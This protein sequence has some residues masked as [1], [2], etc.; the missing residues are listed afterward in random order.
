MKP[1]L[2][3]TVLALGFLAGPLSAQRP[4]LERR[5]MDGPRF[6]LTFVAG[7]RADSMLAERNLD[8]LMSQFG[9]HFEQIVVPE[10]G[11]PMFVIQE[12]VMIGA[13]EQRIAIPSLSLMMGVRFPS[14]FEFGVGPNVTP[15][16]PALAIGIGRSIDY[17]G[18]S[19]PLNLVL[20]HSQGAERFGVIIGYAIQGR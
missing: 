18:V 2:T 5:S 16:G 12:V 4:E 20:V 1:T 9:W 14:G 7:Q 11:G 6:G 10:G 17:R 8:P 3:L 15:V 13:V 19:I